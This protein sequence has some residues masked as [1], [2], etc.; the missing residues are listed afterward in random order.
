MA[1]LY[2]QYGDYL[3]ETTSY[4]FEGVDGAAVKQQLL[5]SMRNS[6]LTSIAGVEVTAYCDFLSQTIYDLPKADVMRFNCADG[7][8]LIVRPSGT[9]PLIK[10]YI[11]T[12]GDKQSNKKRLADIKQQLNGIFSNK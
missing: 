7:S 11:T 8:Q 3:I 6:P 5:D 2:A 12:V 9:E 10:C 1:E 4:R